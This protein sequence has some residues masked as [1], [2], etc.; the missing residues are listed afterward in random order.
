MD[1]CTLGVLILN[2]YQGSK[3]NP[4]EKLII[5]PCGTICVD[6]SCLWLR[7]N[8]QDGAGGC[9]FQRG[10]KL[11]PNF[12]QPLGSWVAELKINLLQLA[13]DQN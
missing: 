10:G 3:L 2:T 13:R 5:S 1:N 4:V 8:L 7:G 9:S 11:P 12:W 6:Q